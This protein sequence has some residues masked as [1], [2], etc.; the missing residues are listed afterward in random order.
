MMKI[1]QEEDITKPA[2]LKD[3]EALCRYNLLFAFYKTY[4]CHYGE[5]KRLHNSILSLDRVV[6]YRAQADAELK[7]IM[8]IPKD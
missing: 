7:N 1:D 6:C 2:V 5:P 4:Q 8:A 3:K